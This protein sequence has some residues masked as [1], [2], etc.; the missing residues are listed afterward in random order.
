MSKFSFWSNEEE[1]TSLYQIELQAS[2]A[3]T[4]IIVKDSKGER[5][6]SSTAKRILSLLE[7]QLR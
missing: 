7:E 1:K 3:S 2:G 4:N 6:D 5:D